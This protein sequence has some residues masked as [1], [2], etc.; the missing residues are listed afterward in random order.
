MLNSR[1]HKADAQMPLTLPTIE[2]ARAVRDG[3]ID[4]MAALNEALREAIELLPPAQADELKRAFG[5]VMGDLVEEIINPAIK[6]F[7]EL[8]PDPATWIAVH[9]S[10]HCEWFCHHFLFFPP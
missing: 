5:R 7:P 10:A 8:D 9:R 3:G 2:C 6:A 1:K 4:A